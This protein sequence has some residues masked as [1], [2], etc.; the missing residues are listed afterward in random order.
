MDKEQILTLGIR[1][2]DDKNR[3]VIPKKAMKILNLKSGGHVA[4]E[5]HGGQ[6]CLLKAYYSVRRDNNI[7]E[8]E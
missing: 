3:V 8:L 2:L 6:I 1:K 7:H 4:I 5:Q